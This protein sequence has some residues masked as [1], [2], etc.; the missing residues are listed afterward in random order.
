MSEQSTGKVY[1]VGAGPGDVG[2]I[3]KRAMR[4]LAEAQVV[5]YDHLANPALLTSCAE[6]A[7]LIYVGKM[8]GD[9]T[10]SQREIEELLI[11]RAR[12]GKVVVR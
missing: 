12:E 5:V 9:H 10:L 4:C 7:E 6:Q 3:S 8:A 11:A 2:L 1:L